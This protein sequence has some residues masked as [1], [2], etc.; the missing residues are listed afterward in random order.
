MKKVFY[1]LSI[2]T[3]VSP[4]F[5]DPVAGEPSHADSAT[6]AS[7]QPGYALMN[8]HAN[9]TNAASAGYV[10]GAY[11]ATLKAVNRVA[12]SIPTS[13]PGAPASGRASVWVE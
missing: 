9:D 11:N 2:L 5:A 4:V 7:A 13:N 8:S 12:D 1:I 3:I 10:K 6:V